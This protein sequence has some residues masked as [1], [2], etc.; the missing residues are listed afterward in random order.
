MGQSF[1]R[2]ILLLKG[3]V[4]LLRGCTLYVREGFPAYR[5]RSYECDVVKS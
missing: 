2:P 5:Q 3:E 4:D 1:G